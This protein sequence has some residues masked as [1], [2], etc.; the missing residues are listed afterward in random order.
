[1]IFLHALDTL[2]IGLSVYGLHEH[3]KR[4]LIYTVSIRRRLDDGCQVTSVQA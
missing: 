3:K 2:D 1:M 4:A